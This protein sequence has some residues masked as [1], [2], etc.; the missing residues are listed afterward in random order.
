MTQLEPT[1]AAPR[2]VEANGI[3]AIDES[4]HRGTP[5]ELFWP[6]FA[7]NVSVFGISYA[8]FILYAGVSF[9]QAL[10]VG[11]IGIVFSFLLCGL[12]SIAGKRGN[13]PT[14]T[15]SRAA[16]GTEG[17]RLPSLISWVLTVG[18]E[19][20]LTALAV[21]ATSTVFDALGWGGGTGAKII[22]LVVV[23]ALIV[24]G[25]ILGFDFIMK[26]QKWITIVTGVLTVVFVIVV[27][28]KIDWA[29]VSAL[30]AGSLG[31]FIGALVLVMTGFGL[32]WVNAAADYSRYLPRSASTRGVVGW[33]TL[34]GSI[35]PILLVI[36]G[37]LLAG[38]STDLRDGIAADP[39]G[40]LVT[41]VPTWFLVPFGIVAIL[42][43][44]GGAVLDI[45]SS[46]LALLSVGLKAPRYVAASIDGVLMIAGAIYVVFIADDFLGPFQGFLITLGVPIAVWCGIFLADVQ[47][48]KQPYAIDE[49]FSRTG[50]YGTVTVS[51]VVLVVVG[52]IIGW[53]LVVST[54]QGF[55]WQGYFMGILGGK[56][57]TL[58][59]ANIGVLVA[60][61]LGY[62][63][64]LVLR[65]DAVRR[66]EALPLI[67]TT[68]R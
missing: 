15:L 19:T 52:T 48:R 1:Q 16:F 51:A 56:A 12:V 41:T 22:A 66:Q 60:L 13:A 17:N 64:T 28:N 14:M 47:L 43:L 54:Y 29:V 23:A 36:F 30:P 49:L 33:T 57:G 24:I 26:L 45:Y 68:P 32:G 25:G 61:V 44:I 37:L 34:G 8:A 42:G 4:E 18:W 46:G 9:W 62:V 50:R 10:I 7:A 40:A 3:N 5:R 63:V 11:V 65:R 35:A 53:G 67:A 55:G 59:G 6:W 38:S 20:A 27:A 58:G 21:L 31:A 39:I 2:G